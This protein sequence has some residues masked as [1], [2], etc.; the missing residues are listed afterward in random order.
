MQFHRCFIRAKLFDALLGDGDV[1]ALDCNAASLNGFSNLNRVDRAKDFSAFAGFRSNF[2]GES[3]EFG[4][5]L[6]RFFQSF[7]GFVRLL[8]DDLCHDFLG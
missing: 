4:L 6:L 7:D 8:L 1:L 3:F 2:D 5:N